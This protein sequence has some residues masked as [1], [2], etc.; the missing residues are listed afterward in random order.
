[1]SGAQ[2]G[3]AIVSLIFVFNFLVSAVLRTA[4]ANHLRC[5]LTCLAMQGFAVAAALNV[6]LTDRFG[7][8]KVRLYSLGVTYFISHNDLHR[9]CYLSVLPSFLTRTKGS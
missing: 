4:V 7:F 3:F 2:I 6:Y 8:G 1:M 9:R 5:K